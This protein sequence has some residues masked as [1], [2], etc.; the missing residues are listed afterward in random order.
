MVDVFSLRKRSQIMAQV[1][2]RDTTPERRVRAQLHDLLLDFEEH[3]N[4][5]A[6]KPDFILRKEKIAIFVHGCFWH[7]HIRCKHATLPTS[8]VEYWTKK[9]GR[10]K[11]RDANHRKTLRTLGWRPLV[12]W[13][14]QI[15]TPNSRRRLRAL[16]MR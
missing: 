3:P 11:T 2:S 5:V 13:E 16:R 6:G 12:F 1:K 15:Q 4:D 10:N 8:N 14:C 9:I 7:G